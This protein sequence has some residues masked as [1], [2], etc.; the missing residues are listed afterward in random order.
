MDIGA[1]R[2]MPKSIVTWVL[3]ADGARARLFVNDGVGK[4]IKPALEQEFIGTNLPSR[5][6]ASD[7]PGRS[8]DSGGEGRHAMEPATDP[9]RHEKQV[10]ARAIADLLD[11][12]RKKN[13]FERLVIVAPPRALGD[14]RSEFGT[15]L[16]GMVSAELNKDLTKL[17]TR[18]LPDH[19]GQVMAV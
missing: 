17:P 11:D 10:F 9:Q 2:S 8:F 13:A 6:I 1:D 15:E 18:D 19:L 7:R 4:G 14:L 5:E 3:V 16:M 12:A